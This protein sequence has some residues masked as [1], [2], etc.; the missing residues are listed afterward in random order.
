M[1]LQCGS[2]VEELVQPTRGHVGLP[3]EVSFSPDT[4]AR[5][6]QSV[7]LGSKIRSSPPSC[8]SSGKERGLL[9][10]PSEPRSLSLLL[11]MERLIP[12]PR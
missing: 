10:A 8:F 9:K 3:G 12:K 5:Y 11:K 7:H 2:E 6:L 4:S 1:G